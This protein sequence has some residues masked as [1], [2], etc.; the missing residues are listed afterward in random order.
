MRIAGFV[1]AMLSLLVAAGCDAAEDAAKDVANDAA[2]S[3]AQQAMDEASRRAKQAVA[4][5]EADPQAAEREL[6]ALRDSLATVEKQVDGETEGQVTR[7]RQALDRLVEQADAARGGTP[8][9]D[10]AVADA[11]S[12]LDAAVEDFSSVC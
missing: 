6:R 10:E 5:L 8:V 7:A 4:D 1:L 3:V 9:D 11:R 12:D 2:C